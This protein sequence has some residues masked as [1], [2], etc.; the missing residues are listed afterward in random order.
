VVPMPP[1]WV[2]VITW[3]WVVPRLLIWAAFMPPTAEAERATNCEVDRAANPLVLIPAT[4]RLV[5]EPMSAAS[6]FANCEV[7]IAANWVDV[8]EPTCA[9]VRATMWF[10]L[11]AVMPSVV[12]P[13]TAAPDSAARSAVSRATTWSVVSFDTWFEVSDAAWV[14]VKAAILLV[15]SD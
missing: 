9:A 13:F 4:A 1:I 5:M 8:R 6:I 12:K 14:G 11:S 15:V 7:L 3:I 10:V 2:D